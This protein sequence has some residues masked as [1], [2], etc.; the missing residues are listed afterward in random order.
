MKECE[1]ICSVFATFSK[2]WHINVQNTEKRITELNT[3][4]EKTSCMTFVPNKNRKYEKWV[5][6][7]PLNDSWSSR[8]YCYPSEPVHIKNGSFRS[9]R[10]WFEL[11]P[12]HKGF[13]QILWLHQQPWG[14]CFR[15]NGNAPFFRLRKGSPPLTQIWK[16]GYTHNQIA[17]KRRQ[18]EAEVSYCISYKFPQ[19]KN[20]RIIR[21][22]DGVI[23][24]LLTLYQ[25]D[26]LISLYLIKLR[27]LVTLI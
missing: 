19:L 18:S 27:S 25:N 23:T 15:L 14:L 4:A 20:K 17:Q 8:S 6:W 9:L 22:F 13:F 24:K 7:E 1:R 11:I 10:W 5:S 21:C 12:A 26:F 3:F 16:R 2:V